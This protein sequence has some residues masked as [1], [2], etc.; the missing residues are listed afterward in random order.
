MNHRKKDQ[1]GILTA[2]ILPEMPMYHL[3]VLRVQALRRLAVLARAAAAYRKA[4][5]E[6]PGN[7]SQ[8]FP[9]FIP[10]FIKEPPLDPF[11]GQPL[12]MKKLTDGLDLFSIGASEIDSP[13]PSEMTGPIHFYLGKKAYGDYR[14]QSLF[15]RSS[16]R[17]KEEK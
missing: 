2:H 13:Y 6:F 14:G 8:L 3:R 17:F 15:S 12:K 9:E 11:D 7:F 5:G 1:G 16:P 4:R 10:E